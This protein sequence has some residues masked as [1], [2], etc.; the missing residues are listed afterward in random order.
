MTP[1]NQATYCNHVTVVEILL[2]QGADPDLRDKQVSKLLRTQAVLLCRA[3]GCVIAFA[4]DVCRSAFVFSALQAAC[5][6]CCKCSSTCYIRLQDRVQQVAGAL[7]NFSSNCSTSQHMCCRAGLH[8]KGCY[9]AVT[10]QT[11]SSS[12]QYIEP[13]HTM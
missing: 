9:A 5:Q 2:A 6:A 10:M 8:L 12:S 11:S 7:P 4:S 3:C 1:L 13:K